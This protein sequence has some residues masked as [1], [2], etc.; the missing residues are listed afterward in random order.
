MD[1]KS[2]S[3]DDILIL[4]CSAIAHRI[5]LNL[6][7]LSYNDV[8]VGVIY[9]FIRE[10]GGLAKKFKTNKFIFAFD[11]K[12]SN[13]L[14]RNIFPQYKEIDYK[15]TLTA[16]EKLS[17]VFYREQIDLLK[18]FVLPTLGYR[19]IFLCEGYESDDVIA[20]AVAQVIDYSKSNCIIVSSDNDLLQLLNQRCSIWDLANKKII[21]MEDFVTKYGIDPTQWGEVKAIAGCTGDGVNGIERVGIDTAIKYLHK[22]IKTISKAYKRIECPKG[23]ELIVR[24]RKLV[25]LPFDGIPMLHINFNNNFLNINGFR[26]ICNKYGFRSLLEKEE[27]FMENLGIGKESGERPTLLN[28][29]IQNYTGQ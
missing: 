17:L 19:N 2:N 29:E 3:K 10:M 21:T 4:D 7:G 15:K 20:Q 12:R 11:D 26:E 13:L 25:V 14:R 16:D 1:K 28:R 6:I 27:F 24:N 18:D 9:G 22:E 23:I 8:K 5:R